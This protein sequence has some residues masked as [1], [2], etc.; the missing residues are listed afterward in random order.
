MVES[1]TKG[2]GGLSQILLKAKHLNGHQPWGT[3]MKKWG[4]WQ[5]AT[6][7]LCKE[8][9]E[10]AEHLIRCSHVTSIW[11]RAI[12][13]LQEW[14]RQT[15]TDTVVGNVIINGITSFQRGE[16]PTIERFSLPQ[17]LSDAALEQD[18]LG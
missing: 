8:S 15:R 10:D 2:M 1:A 18:A 4:F 17:D 6:C 11:P 12:Q 14:F 16:T 7:P 5:D 13:P 9:D 3:S